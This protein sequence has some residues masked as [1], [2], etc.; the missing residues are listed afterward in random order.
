MLAVAKNSDGTTLQFSPNWTPN[1]LDKLFRRLL[2][3]PFRW[4]D[5]VNPLAEGEYHWQMVGKDNRNAYLVTD[6]PDGETVSRFRTGGRGRAYHEREV[7]LGKHLRVRH[8]S[9]HAHQ[10]PGSPSRIQSILIGTQ[11]SRPQRRV[12]VSLGLK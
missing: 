5:L 10:F 3:Q 8:D 11:L 6:T 4:L 2:P 9:P 7:C 1:K 12:Q